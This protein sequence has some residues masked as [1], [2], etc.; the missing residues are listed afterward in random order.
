MQ[1]EMQEM[2]EKGFNYLS[3]SSSL[4]GVTTLFERDLEKPV[5]SDKKD[6][7]MLAAITDSTTEKEIAEAISSGYQFRDITRIGEFIV[8]LDRPRQ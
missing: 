7:K 1:T 8:V 5:G 4:G 2:G 3:P 6:Y